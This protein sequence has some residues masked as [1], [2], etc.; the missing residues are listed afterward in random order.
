M[1]SFSKLCVILCWC[2]Q[3]LVYFLCP[4]V[5]F[6]AYS[7]Y[8]LQKPQNF[9]TNFKMGNGKYFIFR[10][11]RSWPYFSILEISNRNCSQVQLPHRMSG[12]LVV[13][14]VITKIT[15]SGFSRTTLIFLQY[16]RVQFWCSSCNKMIP[17]QLL[18]L[19]HLFIYVTSRHKIH[20]KP[21]LGIIHKSGPMLVSFG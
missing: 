1:Y 7:S 17:Q 12:N 2:C 18:L 6:A 20:N 13:F 21:L 5:R 14:K 3:S 4:C 11:I 15:S 10:L 8:F 16:Y 9:E 19:Y